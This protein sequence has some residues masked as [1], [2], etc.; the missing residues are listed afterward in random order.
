MVWGLLWINRDQGGHVKTTETA[1]LDELADRGKV[2]WT[3]LDS[4]GKPWSQSRS[5][6][7]TQLECRVA[8]SG[9]LLVAMKINSAG[10]DYEAIASDV[11][12]GKDLR[13]IPDTWV[14]REVEIPL[15]YLRAIG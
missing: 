8:E 11:L 13:E 9:R 3:M 4:R 12:T 15:H 14:A 5:G 10:L 6:R 2:Q 1:L 7:A